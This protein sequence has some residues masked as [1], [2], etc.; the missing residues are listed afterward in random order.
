MQ[1]IFT[2]KNIRKLLTWYDENRRDLPWRQTRDPY[3]IWLSEIMLQQTRVEAVKPY[4][5]QF[6]QACPHVEALAIIPEE[7]LLKLWEGLGYYSR[8]RNLQRAA[9]VV[10]E[11]HGGQIPDTYDELLTL[12]GVGDYTAGAIASIAFHR[13]VPAIDGNVLRVLARLQ[14]SRENILLPETKKRW[15]AALS[16]LIPS[17]AGDF[18]Q[19]LIELGATVCVPNG[20]AKCQL[21]P[22]LGTC[23]AQR[24]GCVDELPVR[25]AK[26][27]RRV[28]EKTVLILTDG[29]RTALSKRPEKGLLAGLYEL[30]NFLGH[31]TLAQ[32]QARLNEEGIPFSEIRP[33]EDAKHIFTHIEWHMKAY[34]VQV[35]KDF[36]SGSETLSLFMADNEG[37][38]R[39]YAIPSAFSA[40][41]KY[42]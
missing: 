19:A 33:L 31:L 11:Q 4:Y 23:R 9:R 36:R 29:R 34:L 6:L 24:E 39:E 12:P 17:R 8:A 10:L 3:C 5:H 22:F 26:K 20:E 7:Y 18:N 21:C 2:A 38:E 40:Y 15:R 42:L 41:K 30:P 16:S 1:E 13:R 27:P 37:L 32:V 25:S 14:A 28:E 35:S